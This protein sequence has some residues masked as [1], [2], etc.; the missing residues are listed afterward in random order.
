M[1][2][3]LPSDNQIYLQNVFLCSQLKF[4]LSLVIDHVSQ[5]RK[6]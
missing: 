4:Q 3:I 6:Q 5:S 2:Q 1:N